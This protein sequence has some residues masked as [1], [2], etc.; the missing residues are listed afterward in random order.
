MAFPIA[1]NTAAKTCLTMDSVWPQNDANVLIQ[2][3]IRFD[4]VDSFGSH[5]LNDR[6]G[7]GPKV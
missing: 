3:R 5:Y 6:W 2:R 4:V 7:D 1:E